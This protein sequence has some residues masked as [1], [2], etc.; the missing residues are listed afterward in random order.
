MVCSGCK[1]H[2]K[3]RYGYRCGKFIGAYYGCDLGCYSARECKKNNYNKKE[4]R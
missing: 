3:P 2:N 4:K 1:Y